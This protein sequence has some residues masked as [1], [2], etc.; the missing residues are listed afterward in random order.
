MPLYRKENAIFCIQNFV[1]YNNK[2]QF[3]YYLLI[4]NILFLIVIF[5]NYIFI[6]LLLTY[7]FKLI[8]LLY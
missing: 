1:L 3:N 6:S 2:Y 5:I 8:S 4:F 7:N